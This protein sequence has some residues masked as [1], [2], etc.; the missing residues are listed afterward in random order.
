MPKSLLVETVAALLQ[1]SSQ[2]SQE[3]SQKQLR[4][5]LKDK[6]AKA[7]RDKKEEMQI[8][9]RHYKRSKQLEDEIEQ[10]EKAARAFDS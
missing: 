4:K 10:L 7:R 3:Q 8:A 9:L 2:V 6:L 1:P 5:F